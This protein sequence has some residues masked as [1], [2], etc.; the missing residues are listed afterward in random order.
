[1]LEN[2]IADML[3][4]PLEN[5]PYKPE[6]VAQ[7]IMQLDL[8]QEERLRIRMWL[9]NWKGRINLSFGTVTFVIPMPELQNKLGGG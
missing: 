9:D 6:D 3:R 5:T 7:A 2:K 8:G 4:V 1:M